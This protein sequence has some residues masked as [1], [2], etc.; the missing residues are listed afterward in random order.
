MTRQ[1]S[2]EEDY[3]GD[4]EILRLLE[5]SRQAFEGGDKSQLMTCVF[6][7]ARF[8][9]VIPEWAADALLAIQEGIECGRIANFNEAFGKPREKVNTRA[10]RARKEKVRPEV[11]AV[12]SGLRADGSS[13]NDAEM[14]EKA[15]EILRGRGLN[16][17]HRDIQ[18]IYKT[19]GDFLQQMP[20]GPDP[21]RVY[22]MSD[23]TLPKPRRRGR[24]ILRD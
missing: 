20:R 18:E 8:Q 1:S 10:A 3:V 12:L 23:V 19:H 2:C 15:L 5:E 14:F 16:V 9:A 24:N 13:L 4:A 22:G 7:C 11:L 17:N 6:R 21:Q